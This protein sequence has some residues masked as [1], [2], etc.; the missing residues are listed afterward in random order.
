MDD[1]EGSKAMQLHLSLNED[2]T[3]ALNRL[4]NKIGANASDAAKTAL[5]D[6]LIHHGYLDKSCMDTDNRPRTKGD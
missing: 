5:R 4:G 3:G 2:E 1:A 6:W